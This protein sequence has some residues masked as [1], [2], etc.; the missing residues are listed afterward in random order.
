MTIIPTE[1]PEARNES[2][3]GVDLSAAPRRAP[4]GASWTCGEGFVLVDEWKNT[5][6]HDSRARYGLAS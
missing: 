6:M 2:L 4:D 1:S 3:S 5:A